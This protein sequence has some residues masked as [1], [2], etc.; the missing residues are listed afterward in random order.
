MSGCFLRVFLMNFSAALCSGTNKAST[1]F[2]RRAVGGGSEEWV[3]R[4]WGMGV[5]R[6]VLSGIRVNTTPSCGWLIRTQGESPARNIHIT[7]MSNLWPFDHSAQISLK[8]LWSGP[9]TSQLRAFPC[10]THSVSRK[11]AKQPKRC[12][13]ANLRLGQRGRRKRGFT[14]PYICLWS[15]QANRLNYL[16]SKCAMC[17]M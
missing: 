14:Q 16:F 10:V 4:G 15:H 3:G 9:Y 8:Y 11:Q 2:P 7:C 13:I 1:T 5:E 6:D 17:T 12:L